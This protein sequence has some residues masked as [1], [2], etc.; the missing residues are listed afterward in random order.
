MKKVKYAPL[1]GDPLYDTLTPGKVY[2]VLELGFTMT[3]LDDN[4]KEINIFIYYKD[5]VPDFLD[6]TAQSRAE[7]IDTILT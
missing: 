7:V 4:G 3:L 2:D 1:E 6:Y 5:G